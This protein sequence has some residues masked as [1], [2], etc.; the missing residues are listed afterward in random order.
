MKKVLKNTIALMSSIMFMFSAGC[1]SSINGQLPKTETGAVSTMQ[2]KGLSQSSV[3][4]WGCPATEKIL[5]DVSKSE[6][7][8]VET[9]AVIDIFMAKGEYESGQII[10]TPSEDISYYNATI[11]D[12]TLEGGN[13]KI[14]KEKI[15]VY[16]EKYLNISVNY[17]NNGA[18]L[19]D[20][21][22]GLVPVA[23][24]VEYGQNTIKANTNQGI[25]VT[26]ETA[27]DQEPGIYK[28]S[29]TL[30]FK[31][32]TQVVPVT[33]QV[34]DLEVSE[35]VRTKSVFR[36]NLAYEH[37]ELNSSQ[38]MF[39]AYLDALVKYRLAPST[40]LFE[41][42][43]SDDSIRRYVEKA[44]EYLVDP[45]CSNV[46][47][48][49]LEVTK[50]HS[51]GKSYL[52]IDPTTLEA[53][54]FAFA[55]MSMKK[56]FNMFEKLVLYNATIDEAKIMGRPEAQVEL[57]NITWNQTIRKVAA[58]LEA[59]GETSE[60][61]TELIHSL[62]NIPYIFTTDYWEKFADPT[63]DFYANVFCPMTD[64]C[65]SE[66]GRAEYDNLLEKWWYTC[67]RPYYPQSNY[68]IDFTSVIPIRA[69]GW[70]QADYGF[71][72]NLYWS[73]NYYGDSVKGDRYLFD[74]DYFGGSGNKMQ[75]I[76][77]ANGEGRLFYPGGQYGLDYPLPS[78]RIEGIRDGLEEYELIY[79]LKEKYKELGF[80]ADSLVKTLG[81]SLY[82]G[83]Q[84]TANV[85]QFEQT[86]RGLF[87]LCAAVNSSAE[88]CIIDSKDNNNG[89]IDYKVYIKDGYTLNCDG[90]ALTGGE[91][92]QDGKIYTVSKKL[93]QDVNSINFNFTAD[94][95]NYSYTQA[96]GGKITS[97]AAD[98]LIGGFKKLSDKAPI[99]VSLVDSVAKVEIGAT[100]NATQWFQFTH[101]AISS[102]DEKAQKASFFIRNDGNENITLSVS[103]E[104]SKSKG[105][106]TEVVAIEL[107][108]GVN[109]VTIDV[110]TTAWAK[111]GS[112][113]RLL[114]KFG[115]SNTE[116]AKTVYFEKLLVYGK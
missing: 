55:D 76:S 85:A 57:N 71:V 14:A 36:A 11:S 111:I 21:P 108:P 70:E 101:N 50:I 54:L 27:I 77:S 63:T 73:V 5:A 1:S 24:V 58:A 88:M 19:G 82:T 110:A 89:A 99:T 112:M 44:Y 16:A 33:V 20:Y 48:P 22:D 23:S 13:A 68:H 61:K 17:N 106:L 102:L 109:V 91:A 84:V 86:R 8:A 41:N 69:M 105:K 98:Q 67:N 78:L 52:C 26:F 28:G 30:D 72:G 10:I 113:E 66:A 9:D 51:D 62:L 32:F 18:P 74:E 114:F 92:Y 3:N 116:T 38:E 2:A 80:S 97:I 47:I 83:T 56:N 12:L 81:A 7:S 40:V 64:H 45:R 4:V 59:D 79:S 35:T 75:L 31:D 103:A 115:K 49:Y 60:F 53:Y 34:Y 94:G 42:N 96:L 39:E 25:Y 87:E 15:T 29:L 46:S 104:F 100:V 37:G 90:K 95:K 65:N 6:Y 107:K 93:D 43:H